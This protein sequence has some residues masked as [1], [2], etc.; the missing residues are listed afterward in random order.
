[1]R[2]DAFI[3]QTSDEHGAMFDG[4]NVVRQYFGA[5]W[6]VSFSKWS[7][8]TTVTLIGRVKFYLFFYGIS[9]K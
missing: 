3:G 4:W 1:M 5:P 2:F 7:S 9:K 8:N 6:Q